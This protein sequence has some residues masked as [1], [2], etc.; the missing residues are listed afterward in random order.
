LVFGAALAV[1]PLGYLL[2]APLGA[3]ADRAAGTL[4]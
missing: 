4:F 2:I 1:S 3:F